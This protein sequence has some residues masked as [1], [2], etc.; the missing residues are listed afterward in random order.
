MAEIVLGIGT[1]HTPQM[2]MVPEL[3]EDH[4]RRDLRNPQL[5][6]N[7]GEVHSFQGLLDGTPSAVIEQLGI[8]EYRKKH[9]R[10]QLGLNLL[11]TPLHEVR[12]DVVVVVGD[13]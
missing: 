7:D 1:S 12:P 10:A 2:T 11:V 6:G 4:A 3:W 13:D 9:A 5:I 8:V